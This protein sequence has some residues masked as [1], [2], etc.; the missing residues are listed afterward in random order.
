MKKLLFLATFLLLLGITANIKVYALSPYT[1]IFTTNPDDQTD[2]CGTAYKD[3]IFQSAT[4][5]TD[6]LFVFIPY[7]I[8]TNTSTVIK[9][10]DNTTFISNIVGNDLGWNL[11]DLSNYETGSVDID[12]IVLCYW[13]EYQHIYDISG[14]PAELNKSS[15]GNNQDFYDSLDDLV[16]VETYAD[17]YGAGY[18]QATI[19]NPPIID[20]NSDTYDDTSYTAGYSAGSSEDINYGVFTN[21]L[22]EM[23]DFF[24]IEIFPNVSFGTLAM[25]PI[26]FAILAWFIKMRG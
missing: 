18:A 13:N 16:P 15:A 11:I 14:E 6:Y 26:A 1:E 20:T 8:D 17:G 23:G 22:A 21:L 4:F 12:N 2:L 10:Y 24:T 25:I 9:L 3:Y 7:D 19:D 5:T